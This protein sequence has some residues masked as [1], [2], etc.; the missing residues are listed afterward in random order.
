MLDL[1]LRIDID[2]RKPSLALHPSTYDSPFP[3]ARVVFA[4]NLDDLAGVQRDLMG[5]HCP[6]RYRDAVESAT[7]ANARTRRN[8][9][10]V[11]F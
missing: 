6:V 1:D 4:E 7:E 2:F 5:H 8:S 3:P 10:R 11:R 9:S